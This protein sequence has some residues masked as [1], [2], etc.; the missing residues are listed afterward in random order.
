MITLMDSIAGA[1]MF[2]RRLTSLNGL[3]SNES[4]M[5]AKYGCSLYG[6]GKDMKGNER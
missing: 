6:N 4:F 2:Q 1:I 3:P 5:A